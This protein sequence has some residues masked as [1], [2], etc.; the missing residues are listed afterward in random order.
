[1]HFLL[2]VDVDTAI[3]ARLDPL[4][5]SFETFQD[6]GVFVNKSSVDGMQISFTFKDDAS[7]QKD[8]KAFKLTVY[9]LLELSM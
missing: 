5:D 6:E 8:Y 4:L 7:Y 9:Y 1:M 3:E 2:E